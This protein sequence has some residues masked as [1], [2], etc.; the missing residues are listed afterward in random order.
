M[1]LES[2]SA[3]AFRLPGTS[4]A[5]RKRKRPQ[6]QRISA[7]DGSARL[8]DDGCMPPL[9]Y[10]PSSPGRDSTSGM[11]ENILGR[12]TPLKAPENLFEIVGGLR[13]N[14]PSQSLANTAPV[15]QA[16]VRGDHFP[17]Q[18]SAHRRPL[19]QKRRGSPVMQSPGALGC[20]QHS[21][22]DPVSMRLP[23]TRTPSCGGG[24]NGLR[25]WQTPSARVTQ[26]TN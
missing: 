1:P 13:S 20:D 25:G 11:E 16:G 21:A 3:P 4:V 14:C 8:P 22:Q 12:G 5:L 7:I 17:G 18:D 23:R 2:R 15:C 19:C 9:W 10:C 26:D 6:L 24:P